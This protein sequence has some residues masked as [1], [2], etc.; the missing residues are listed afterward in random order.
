[1]AI[2]TSKKLQAGDH[3]EFTCDACQRNYHGTIPADYHGAMQLFCS[4]CGMYRGITGAS[5]KPE[6]AEAFRMSMRQAAT[7]ETTSTT[8]K[9]T[10]G[11][12][13]REVSTRRIVGPSTE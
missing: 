13:S 5:M 4:P 2:N 1:M 6:I 11:K 9:A 3:T 12:F 10:T 8:G 7:I